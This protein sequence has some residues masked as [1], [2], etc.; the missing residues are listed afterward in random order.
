MRIG[1][2][3]VAGGGGQCRP[4]LGV[5]IQPLLVDVQRVA[6]YPFNGLVSGQE[7]PAGVKDPPDM[8]YGM[9]GLGGRGNGPF[10]IHA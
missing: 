3:R 6:F 9:S 5:F 7:G 10:A 2:H 8:F 1:A 4:I